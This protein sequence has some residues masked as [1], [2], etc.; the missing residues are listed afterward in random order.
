MQFIARLMALGACLLF[1]GQSVFAQ[2]AS[3]KYYKLLPYPGGCQTANGCVPIVF[4]HMV[5]GSTEEGACRLEAPAEGDCNWSPMLN[6]LREKPELWAKIRPYI[7]RY[8][9][10]RESTFDIGR[11][12]QAEVDAEEPLKTTPFII[13]AHSMGGI[14]ARTF[15]L[16]HTSVSPDPGYKRILAAITLATPHH[17]TPAANRTWRNWQADKLSV[18]L[19]D[20]LPGD[21][22]NFSDRMR[23]CPFDPNLNLIERA[24]CLDLNFMTPLP[25]H[26]V[27]VDPLLPNRADLV[28]D[29]YDGYFDEAEQARPNHPEE[30]N[31]LLSTL[32][33]SDQ[34]RKLIVYGG[35]VE[36][37]EISPKDLGDQL[38]D[39][40]KSYLGLGCPRLTT[41]NSFCE[42]VSHKNLA[43]TETMLGDRLAIQGSDGIVPLHSALFNRNQ[44]VGL[45]RSG[46][47]DYDH[48][49]M[50]GNHLVDKRFDHN[51]R[52]FDYI[53][54]DL[55]AVM[56]W[57]GVPPR[58][59]RLTVS[60]DPAVA[61]SIVRL[62][63]R[64]KTAFETPARILLKASMNGISSCELM[65]TQPG[66]NSLERN[67]Q[68]PTSI[69]SSSPAIVTGEV[70]PETATCSG[71]ISSYDIT[72]MDK[73]VQVVP[74]LSF[75]RSPTISLSTADGA[76][77]EYRIGEAVQL[78][79]A[80]T[81]GVISG[82]GAAPP[83]ST[84]LYRDGPD[85]RKFLILKDGNLMETATPSPVSAPTPGL[86]L[87]TS[88]PSLPVLPSTPA[89]SYSWRAELGMN[90]VFDP[91]NRL[92]ASAIVNY[93][94][95]SQR[96][97]FPS[98]T[99]I[100]TSKNGYQTGDTMVINYATT[101]GSSGAVYDLMLR[102]TS[103][104]SGNNYYFYDDT[105]DSNR[106]IHTIA[107]PML[108]GVPSDG[109]FQI[110]SG[111]AAPIVIE[112]ST[113]SGD[114]SMLA[115]FSETGKN[116]P[117]GGTATS[118]YQL[119]TPTAEGGC[120]VATAAFGSPMAA[121][122]ESL[123][124]FRDRILLTTHLGRN[125]VATY[126]RVGPRF[127]SVIAPR[128]WL[129]K[130]VRI[131][132]WP[133]V[134]FGATAAIYGLWVAFALSVL[135]PFALYL[136]WRRAPLMLRF[137]L[138]AVLAAS[139]SFAAQL[140]GTV[141]QSKPFPAPI[142]GARVEIVNTSLV[143]T[144]DQYGRFTIGSVS[145]GD[146]TVRASAAG[147][148]SG[149]TK[150]SIT[151]A[152]GTFSTV[153]TATPAGARTYEYYLPHTAE[154]DGWWTA[155]TLLN[156]NQTAADVIMTAY[157][158]KGSYLGTSTQIS[159][160]KIGQQIAGAPSQY[161][162][163]EII[164]KA[165]YYKFTSSAPITGF[166]IFGYKTGTLAG[167]PLATAQSGTV[168]LPH[169]ADDSY[170][171]TG[172]G[173]VSGATRTNDLHL[174]ARDR[175]GKLLTEA[176]GAPSLRP[177][178]K[179]VDVL[180]NYFGWDFPLDVS[181]VGVRSVGPIAGFELFGTKDFKM[182]A[183]V[184]ALSRGARNFS[185]P[186]VVTTGGGWTGIAML[187][188]D[189]SSGV[190][191]LKAYASDGRLLATS[192]AV[193]LAPAERTVGVVES[194]FDA[195]PA[196][197]AYVE[198]TSEVD[199]IA[200]E[201]TG[202]FS[203]PLFGGLSA[204]PPLGVAI[205][206][207]YTVSNTDWDT[208]LGIV[209]TSP[210]ATPIVLEAMNKDGSKLREARFS[211]PAKGFRFANLRSLFVTVPS[212]MTWVK[213]R[214]DGSAVLSGFLKLSRVATG[215]YTDIPA[216][217]VVPPEQVGQQT[218]AVRLGAATG[219]AGPSKSAVV[220]TFASQIQLDPV[221]GGG[222]RIGW[223]NAI[224]GQIRTLTN[225]ALT[226]GDIILSIESTPVASISDLRNAYLRLQSSDEAN[227][228]V[229]H[230]DGSAG[231]VR[232]RNPWAI[233]K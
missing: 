207:P 185:F 166:E 165:A 67:F 146:Y 27:A 198:V 92:A 39:A 228:F 78:V 62:T 34:A 25:S 32:A 69:S 139:A 95:V 157:D 87:S 81:A 142:A 76:K 224:D 105:A 145:A 184:P 136:L 37:P 118:S 208:S 119:N 220:S 177:G 42:E 169:I 75:S 120:F 154:S 205:A 193:S 29:N 90:E 56:R 47:I 167:F 72:K 19:H 52:L 64:L 187:N 31:Q 133:L 214:S 232:L 13:V 211:L 196:G 5:D 153:V 53:G 181:W 17:G 68:I 124:Q 2:N 14:V 40:A 116:L 8:L 130:I 176:S 24:L 9:S 194:Y 50:R 141:V 43:L 229:R 58:I 156:P 210:S 55:E 48:Q 175:I 131:A 150:V 127:A 18:K 143:A 88:L 192:R 10:H 99:S 219:A 49:D 209:N 122:V 97:P 45:R 163:P 135:I 73:S 230:Q 109:Q 151:S 89:G 134:G 222:V 6:Y 16:Q 38:V 197:V 195:W 225:G 94:V 82:Q 84:F 158:S 112:S 21:I 80:T 213:A 121:A 106:W 103:K 201:L 200:F 215:E 216:D 178:E 199:L 160:L 183:A 1:F 140:Q 3:S 96:I 174:E 217:G 233:T 129:R 179:T 93:Q 35:L 59:T 123:R 138:L 128:A 152:A 7:F 54:A 36:G 28:W 57:R 110:P 70:L 159:V 113:P 221:A 74:T 104:A 26:G 115:Y 218:S 63:Y 147:Y 20:F 132:L 227:V 61:G 91:Q 101:R 180:S 202:S 100:S 149:S 186:H 65:T 86:D 148:L 223:P 117:V 171:W 33:G 108:T 12:L 125:F 71:A 204:M 170:W 144:S 114:Y 77:K 46:F 162:A 83:I 212:G 168:Y 231:T 172:I 22:L 161:F 23:W 60:P 137:L 4:I 79:L 102:L 206:F 107:R 111:T 203:P 51:G 190:A 41:I 85:G 164:A 30:T 191:R 11:R 155:F 126:Y 15:M 173:F 226:Q 44:Y 98:V 188:S 182:M 189:T 66:E